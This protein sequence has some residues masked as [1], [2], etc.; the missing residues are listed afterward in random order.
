MA[1]DFLNDTKY[2]PQVIQ[3]FS[4]LSPDRPWI[5]IACFNRLNFFKIALQSLLNQ[6]ESDF[7][8]IVTDNSTTD[9][10]EDWLFSTKFSR[11]IFYVHWRPTLEMPYGHI[12]QLLE[13]LMKHRPEYWQIFHDDDIAYP[14]IVATLLRTLKS[15]PEL[16]AVAPNAFEFSGKSVG[17][18]M[19]RD[20]S[21]KIFS[22]PRQILYQYFAPSR[23]IACCPS[24]MYTKKTQ[25][26]F[27]QKLRGGKYIDIWLNTSFAKWGK[28]KWL[29]QP[30]LLYRRHPGQDSAVHSVLCKFSIYNCFVK[31]GDVTKTELL[32]DW[33]FLQNIKQYT[34]RKS[35]LRWSTFSQ[36]HSRLLWLATRHAL[37]AALRPAFWGLMISKVTANSIL[38]FRLSAQVR[39]DAE[40][41]LKRSVD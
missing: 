15:D 33:F 23:G 8:L 30:L 36:I 40:D 25:E 35:L 16:I 19:R 2:S 24:Y 22:E 41:L 31:S 14:E 18:L 1:P 29:G 3:E 6:T 11:P 26:I 32:Y 21:D 39:Q 5:F 34:K 12:Y 28:I 38:K 27:N 10:I 17:A 13:L 9:E 37:R 4:E 7:Y 20:V